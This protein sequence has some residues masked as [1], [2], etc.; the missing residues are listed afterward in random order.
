MNNSFQVILYTK[1]SIVS[2]KNLKAAERAFI[3]QVN[4]I[5][6]QDNDD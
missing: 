2:T 3:I 6:P 4:Y 5:I 1:R